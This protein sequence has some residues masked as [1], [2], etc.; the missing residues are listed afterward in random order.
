MIPSCR[1]QLDTNTNFTGY[2]PYYHPQLYPP[3][4]P[5]A[6][7]SQHHRP[8]PIHFPHPQAAAA[9]AA[10]AGYRYGQYMAAQQKG[11]DAA[12]AKESNGTVSTPPDNAKSFS[13]PTKSEK[14]S[15]D[16]IAAWFASEGGDAKKDGSSAADDGS[17]VNGVA[18]KAKENQLNGKSTKNDNHPAGFPI[19]AP[20]SG[21]PFYPSYPGAQFAHLPPGMPHPSYRQMHPPPGMQQQRTKPSNTVQDFKTRASNRPTAKPA[22]SAKISNNA[23]NPPGLNKAS[24]NALLKNDKA[25]AAAVS[26]AAASKA[27]VEENQPSKMSTRT[28]KSGIWSEQEVRYL[29]AYQCVLRY[30]YRHDLSRYAHLASPLICICPSFLSIVQNLYRMIV[31]AWL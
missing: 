8:G 21:H 3:P 18:V 11:K 14:D 25:M 29:F 22:V 30:V 24:S 5:G 17:V 1:F 27:F 19:H 28:N 13:T 6:K 7:R 12:S 26:A 9:A 10:A 15:L 20:H 4:P 31:F 2:H 23:P 16:D